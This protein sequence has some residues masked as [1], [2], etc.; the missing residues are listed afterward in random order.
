[1][2][3][4]IYYRDCCAS[5]ILYLCLSSSML[6]IFQILPNLHFICGHCCIL[7]HGLKKTRRER[8]KSAP[9]LR[10]K[11]RKKNFGKKTCNFRKKNFSQKKSHSA[12]K[13]KRRTL[14]DV[15]TYIQLQN[16]K[17]LE[18]GTLWTTSP[19]AGLGLRCSGGVRIVSKKW[20]DQCEDCSLKKKKTRRERLKSAPYLRLKKRKTL[21]LEKN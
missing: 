19:L 3:Q 21:F 7:A 10:L 2:L 17:K 14:W 9:Y 18:G 12:K 13:C 4:T 1:M 6:C 16:M 11:K 15:L 20:T 5:S 8:R